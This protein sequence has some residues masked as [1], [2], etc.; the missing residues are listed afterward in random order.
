[1]PQ[2]A[3]RVSDLELALEKMAYAQFN[4]QLEIQRL[5]NEMREFKGEMKAFKDEM[6][7][8]RADL[9]KRWGELANKMGTVVE[10]IVLPNIPR[11]AREHFGCAELE[12]LAPRVVKRVP[13]D[14]SRRR[15]FDVVAVCADR[16]I[17]NETKS[18]PRTT[19]VM[20]FVDFL[21]SGEFFD[22]FPEYAG[23]RLIPIFSS[24]AIPEET[25]ALLSRE[26]I[27]AMAM[28]EETMDLLNAEAVG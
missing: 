27:Y 19:Y 22:Y 14:A 5:S 13:G 8:D 4:T 28:G 1:M 9:N 17:L 26:G 21:R 23:R 3:E 15:E 25:V 12:L 10:D 24:L 16:V 6:R 11:I 20:E 18:T 7:K 2:V